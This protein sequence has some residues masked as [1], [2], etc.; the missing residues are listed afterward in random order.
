MRKHAS[1]EATTVALSRNPLS[2]KPKASPGA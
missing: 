2:F 1:S